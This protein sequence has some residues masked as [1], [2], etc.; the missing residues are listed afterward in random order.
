M[1]K[2]QFLLIIGFAALITSCRS[3]DDDVPTPTSDAYIQFTVN[4]VTYRYENEGTDASAANVY[5]GGTLE[6]VGVSGGSG[7]NSISILDYI[8]GASGTTTI[9]TTIAEAEDFIVTLNLGGSVYS[10]FWGSGLGVPTGDG[11]IEYTTFE[12]DAT[13]A[14][15]NLEGTFSFTLYDLFS[16]PITV[17]GSFSF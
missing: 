7:S 16:N 10:I 1:K 17:T 9:T 12:P 4:G 15:I 11:T 13:L 2:I 8:S 14:N 3:E 6:S 5:S